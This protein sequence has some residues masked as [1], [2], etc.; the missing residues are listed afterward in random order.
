[1]SLL[2]FRAFYAKWRCFPYCAVV[3]AA[4][5]HVL[6]VDAVH[7]HQHSGAHHPGNIIVLRT[8]FSAYNTTVLYTAGNPGEL[9]WYRCMPW[10]FLPQETQFWE[11]DILPAILSLWSRLYILRWSILT[12]HCP[13]SLCIAGAAPIA[14]PDPAGLFSEDGEA[15]ELHMEGSLT[16]P[17][18]GI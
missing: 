12:R 6:A 1:M 3:V 2:L 14:P 15:I 18:T 10:C 13:Y 5:P 4:V 7:S 16:I 9:S 8:R 17:T 11:L